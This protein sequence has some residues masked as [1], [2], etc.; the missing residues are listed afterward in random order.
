LIQWRAHAR[1]ESQLP[2]PPEVNATARESYEVEHDDA[3]PGEQDFMSRVRA[4][5]PF[6]SN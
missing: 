5:I 3:V 2:Y 1:R 4:A 6:G